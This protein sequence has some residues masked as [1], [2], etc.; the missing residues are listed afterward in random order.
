MFFVGYFV[1]AALGMLPKVLTPPLPYRFQNYESNQVV[2]GYAFEDRIKFDETHDVIKAG[3]FDELNLFSNANDDNGT[4]FDSRKNI[5]YFS[6]T[7]AKGNML[8]R[9]DAKKDKWLSN[10]YNNKLVKGTTIKH[11][12]RYYVE[13]FPGNVEVVFDNKGTKTYLSK[14]FD[15]VTE[16]DDYAFKTVSELLEKQVKEKISLDEFTELIALYRENQL[17]G[18]YP[19]SHTAI[20]K[21]VVDD[22]VYFVRYNTQTLEYEDFGPYSEARYMY[23]I[24]ENEILAYDYDK[25]QVKCIDLENG[26]EFVLV[27]G[28]DDKLISFNF[29]KYSESGVVF[30][31]I[32]EDYDIYAR[33]LSEKSYSLNIA[34]KKSITKA[35]ESFVVT[36][37]RV[38]VY[39][40]RDIM[41]W[42]LE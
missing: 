37:D 25:D 4:Y 2:I 27:S 8:L 13:S 1:F 26:K 20:Y 18:W 5:Y 21:M 12:S 23:C 9:Y 24:T 3:T 19:E 29:C 41:W 7:D 30:A 36:K 14:V 34:A 40:D 10:L 32:T 38:M 16:P 17:I 11:G 6:G 39:S 15:G 33:D 42:D 22:N 35:P 31:F 28:I